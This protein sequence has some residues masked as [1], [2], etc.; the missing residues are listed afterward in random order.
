[1]SEP[2]PVI[3]LTYAGPAAEPSRAWRGIVKVCHPL[4]LL[5]CA[6]AWVL[7]VAVHVESVV[8]MGPLLLVL[9]VLLT[10]GGVMAQDRRAMGF[11]IAHAS[12]CLLFFGLVNVLEW[13]P[14][15]AELPFT[16]MGGA[17][18]LIVLALASASGLRRLSG[19]SPGERGMVTL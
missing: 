1:M 12:I 11:G 15:D 8:F 7:L 6:V 18:T 9:G 13:G 14:S 4:A 17:Y 10:V 16:V 2:I 3:P 5:A 19:V